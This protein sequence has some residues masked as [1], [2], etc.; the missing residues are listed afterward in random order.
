MKYSQCCDDN[1]SLCIYIYIYI[2]IYF[3]NKNFINKLKSLQMHN[4][5]TLLTTQ[6][7]KLNNQKKE[8][9]VL[10]QP[11]VNTV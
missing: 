5:P 6:K 7:I 11:F 3:M 9:I 4:S 10:H 1:I 2:Y 8:H